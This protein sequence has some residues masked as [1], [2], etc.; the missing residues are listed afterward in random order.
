VND[1]RRRQL[2]VSD[3]RKTYLVE[4][5]Q[6]HRPQPHSA[7]PR[8]EWQFYIEELDLI[9]V[10]D[11]NR[12]VSIDDPHRVFTELKTPVGCPVSTARESRPA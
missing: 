9:L 5:T 7:A 1:S 4:A 2:T 6:T 8:L 11:G 12:Y 10:Q 3:G